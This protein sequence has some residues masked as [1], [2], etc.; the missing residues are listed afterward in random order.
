[1]TKLLGIAFAATVAWAS[2]QGNVAND[3]A[4][5]DLG[6]RQ[7]NEGDLSS[8]V[9]TLDAV[10]LQLTGGTAPDATALVQAYLYKGIALVGLAQ[11]EPAKTAFR[12]ALKLDPRLRV[13]KGE[14]PD[15]VVR[16][17]DAARQGK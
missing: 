16:V 9:V 1:M 4:S 14:Q 11:E 8:A 3:E 12:E 6:I 13:N 17:F 15:R 10:I 7:V 5:L 2:A